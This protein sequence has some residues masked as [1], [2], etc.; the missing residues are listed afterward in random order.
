[1]VESALFC[2]EHDGGP[3]KV[4]VHKNVSRTTI[5]AFIYI[6]PIVTSL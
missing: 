2:S 6:L 1:M 3:Y 5:V 4:K